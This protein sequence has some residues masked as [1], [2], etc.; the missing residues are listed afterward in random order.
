MAEPAL[1]RGSTARGQRIGYARREPIPLP[2]I[3]DPRSIPQQ[4][5]SRQER[6][7]RRAAVAGDRIARDARAIGIRLDVGKR[8]VRQPCERAQQ[9][10]PAARICEEFSISSPFTFPDATLPSMETYSDWPT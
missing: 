9:Q 1:S 8:L 6:N 4:V 7:R 2:A 3:P 5:H 10:R